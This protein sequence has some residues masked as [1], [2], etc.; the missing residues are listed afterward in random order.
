MFTFLRSIVPVLVLLFTFALCCAVEAVPND[1]D[2]SDKDKADLLN[3]HFE[4]VFTRD[5][6]SLPTS[7]SI[8]YL[9]SSF[10]TAHGLTK[11]TTLERSIRG[12]VLIGCSKTMQMTG[13]KSETH[14]EPHD[15]L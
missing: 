15:H 3:K 2:I 8:S 11:R 10:L 6:G 1:G 9:E 4:S 12:A 14:L 5:N 13:T 7:T